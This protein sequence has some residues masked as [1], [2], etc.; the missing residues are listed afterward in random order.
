M[1]NMDTNKDAWSDKPAD[2]IILTSRSEGDVIDGVNKV[3]IKFGVTEID[4][5]KY[6][7]QIR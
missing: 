5:S 7:Q 2:E 6:P 4:K 1:L 3:A